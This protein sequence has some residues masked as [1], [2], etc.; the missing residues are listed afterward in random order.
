MVDRCFAV[1]V[2]VSH[3]G[4]DVVVGWAKNA[5]CRGRVI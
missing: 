1:G 5:G 4:D 3:G 2:E